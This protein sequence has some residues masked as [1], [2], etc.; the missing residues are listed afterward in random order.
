MEKK[1]YVYEWIDDNG[2]VFYVGKGNGRRCEAHSERNRFFSAHLKEHGGHYVIRFEG[3]DED[4][5]YSI[6]AFLVKKHRADGAPLTN[7]MDGGKLPPPAYSGSANGMYGKTHTQETRARIAKYFIESGMFAG[8]NNPQFGVSPVDRMSPEVYCGWLSKQRANKM[9]SKNPNFGNRMLSE[10]YA[11]NKE[12]AKEKQGRPG[13]KNG[14]CVPLVAVDVET[15]EERF[16]D[17]IAL[18]VEYLKEKVFDVR[19]TTIALNVTKSMND[20]NP[21]Y[22][23]YFI[24][25]NSNKTTS[26]QAS[27]EEGVTIR[28]NPVQE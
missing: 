4:S 13:T 7:I 19:D 26:C 21:R 2:N 22:G 14:R 28:D 3:L 23:H 16:F 18:C 20:G 9:G 6:E 17:Y 5:A 10:K 24:K 15:R 1:F 12:L 25:Q 11:K 27:S 8:E